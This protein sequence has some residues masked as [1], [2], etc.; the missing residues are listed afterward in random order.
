MLPN[1][2]VVLVREQRPVKHHIRMFWMFARSESD[3]HVA[4]VRIISQRQH[5]LENRAN[6]AAFYTSCCEAKRGT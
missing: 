1:L 4:L 2:H 3:V 6:Y 5:I